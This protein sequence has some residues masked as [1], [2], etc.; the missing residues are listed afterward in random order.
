MY[1]E[2]DANVEIRAVLTLALCFERV[3][4]VE[5][6]GWIVRWICLFNYMVSRENGF[7]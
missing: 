7:Y 2:A 4:L 3:V 6:D 5:I 1:N